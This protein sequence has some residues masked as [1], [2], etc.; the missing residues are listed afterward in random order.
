[1]TTSR[2]ASNLLGALALTV[3]DRIDEA[4]ADRLQAG[5]NASAGLLSIGTRP[6]GSVRE[7]ATVLQM[8]HSAVVRLVDRL[9]ARNL[10]TRSRGGADGRVVSLTLT[11]AGGRIFKRLLDDRNRVLRGA[12]DTLTDSEHAQLEKLLVK[13]LGSIPSNRQDA[14]HVCRLC[15]HEVCREDACPVGTAGQ[16]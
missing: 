3:T 2:Y 14:L 12:T 9:V 7:L 5:S 11:A 6:G 4:L 8:S 16:T 10:V 13:M 1:M 15:E